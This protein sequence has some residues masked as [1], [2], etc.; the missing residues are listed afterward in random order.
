MDECLF[1]L[2]QFHIQTNQ[3]AEEQEETTATHVSTPRCE[4]A[5]EQIL[6]IS[7]L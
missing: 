4:H 6:T 7:A 5:L 2:Q 3:R 1:V